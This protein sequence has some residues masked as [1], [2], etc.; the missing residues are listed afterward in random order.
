MTTT[1][2]PDAALVELIQRLDRLWAESD[3]LVAIDEDD[4]RC[5]ALCSE[6][7]ELERRILVTP[8]YPAAGADGKRRIVERAELTEFDDLDLI[9]TIF[10]LDAERIAAAA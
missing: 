7:A 6:C 5:A 4:P 1:T 2:I 3:R 8:A 9:G 10:T